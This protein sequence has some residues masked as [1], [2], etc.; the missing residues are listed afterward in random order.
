MTPLAP[1]WVAPRARLCGQ[2]QPLHCAL[3]VTPSPRHALHRHA[4]TLRTDDNAEGSFLATRLITAQPWPSLDSPPTGSSRAPLASSLSR[5]PNAH[6]SPLSATCGYTRPI[7]PSP[8][9]AAA[10]QS[11]SR[12]RRHA[13]SST[14]AMCTASAAP[15]T[16]GDAQTPA[17]NG[18]KKHLVTASPSMRR[19]S[20]FRGQQQPGLRQ[21]GVGLSTHGASPSLQSQWL[22]CV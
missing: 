15:Q 3:S 20:N 17:L 12:P 19:L 13:S 22:Y 4:A 6:L 5:A 9:S 21:A 11:S 2:P 18:R 7:V 10:G 16:Y 1:C 14:L 8:P